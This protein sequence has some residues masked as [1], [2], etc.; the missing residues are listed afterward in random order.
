M[1]ALVVCGYSLPTKRRFALFRV[2]SLPWRISHSSRKMGS[3][4]RT[5]SGSPTHRVLE[6]YPL[7]AYAGSAHP[8]TP[9][10]LITSFAPDGADWHVWGT[11]LVL[12]TPSIP[13]LSW[14]EVGCQGRRRLH[15]LYAISTS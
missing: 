2:E 9:K 8:R 4:L 1:C 6:S 12:W 10:S 5:F 13:L 14:L 15:H 3:E 11:Y 7:D